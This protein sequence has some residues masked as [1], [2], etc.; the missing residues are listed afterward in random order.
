MLTLQI[1]PDAE[2]RLAE[3]AR[4]AG[5]DMPSY[6]QQILVTEARRPTLRE[7]SGPIGE[8]FAASGMSEDELSDLLEE[9]KHKM[10]SD[11]RAGETK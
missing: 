11:R 5:M 6:A 8:A 4:S 9:A 1:P 10:R 3:K 7:I 2:A